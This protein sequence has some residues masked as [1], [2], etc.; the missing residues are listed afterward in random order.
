MRIELEIEFKDPYG[1][2][3]DEGDIIKKMKLVS[4]EHPHYIDCLKE[5]TGTLVGLGYSGHNEIAPFIDT[6][7]ENGK[8][9][10]SDFADMLD[11]A[12]LNRQVNVV[13]SLECL[14]EL[15]GLGNEEQKRETIEEIMRVLKERGYDIEY[16]KKHLKY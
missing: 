7:R 13:D 2:Q 16:I 11:I 1:E 14:F 8:H 5:I 3:E 9:Y 15:K 6:I 10:Y 12:T 4:S